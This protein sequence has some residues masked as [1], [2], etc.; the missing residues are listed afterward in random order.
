MLITGAYAMVVGARMGPFFTATDTGW[1]IRLASGDIHGVMQPFASRQL[2]PAV[3]RF[4]VWGLHWPLQRAFLLQGTVS[5]AVLLAV[6]LL[7]MMRTATPRWML[8][9]VAVV[10]FWPQLYYGLVLPDL[11]YAALVA[12]FLVLLARRHFLT[13]ACMMFPLMLSRESTS[14][15]LVCFLIAGWR[16]LRWRGRL[17]AVGAA[18]GGMMIVQHLTAHNPGNKEHLPEFVYM[19]SKVPWNFVRNITG[20]EP[21]SNVYPQLCSVPVWQHSLQWGP[22]HAIGVCGISDWLPVVTVYEIVSVF[23]L[24]PLLAAFLWWR[25]RH[26]K[27]RSLL[28]NFCLLYG[29]IT[30]LLSPVLGAGVGRL[31]GYGW[32]FCLVALPL[33]FDELRERYAEALRSKGTV[34]SLGLLGLHLPACALAAA[35]PSLPIAAFGAGLWV[36]GF[37]LLRWWFGPTVEGAGKRLQNNPQGTYGEA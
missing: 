8:A 16:P 24:L 4:L 15:L 9:A 31:L 26:D 5:L 3:A 7:L 23:G 18:L 21:W 29:G 14:L 20:I 17:L 25:S 12:V 36:G 22:V 34:A 2:G 28:L 1:Y 33:L 6:I 19:L 13:A 10:P 27:G 35:T 32:P 11:W 37:L 30:V